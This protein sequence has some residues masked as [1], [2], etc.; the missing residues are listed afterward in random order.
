MDDAAQRLGEPARSR[1]GIGNV[2]MIAVMLERRL[3]G[4]NLAD[5][6]GVL[7]GARLRPPERHAVPA[8][9]HLRARGADAAEEAVA[10]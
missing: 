6:R 4:E 7:A 9:D 8:L 10:G 3:A 1:P 2:V 5:D